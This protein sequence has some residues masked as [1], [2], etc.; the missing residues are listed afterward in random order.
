ML[1]FYSRTESVFTSILLISDFFVGELIPSV[2]QDISEQCFLICVE[3]PFV[4]LD[5]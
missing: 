2:L 3:V 1:L 4:V 5:L